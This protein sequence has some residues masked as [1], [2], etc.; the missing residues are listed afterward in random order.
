MSATVGSN[1][2]APEAEDA[3]ANLRLQALEDWKDALR[4]REELRR[5]LA[6]ALR[7][8]QCES[9]VPESPPAAPAAHGRRFGWAPQECAVPSAAPAPPLPIPSRLDAEELAEARQLAQV[10]SA[11][12]EFGSYGRVRRVFANLAARAVLFFA[13]VI[14]VQQRAFNTLV[15]R[16]VETS[17]TKL[18]RLADGGRRLQSE[19]DRIDTAQQ[20]LGSYLQGEMLGLGAALER[21]IAAATTALQQEMAARDAALRH[22]MAPLRRQSRDG[23]ASAR[24]LEMRLADADCERAWLR[25]A[26]V[27]YKEELRDALQRL[28]ALEDE[29]QTLRRS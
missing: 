5:R 8:D 25:L 16:F 14:T 9:V 29:V 21:E 13:G 24:E 20:G 6:T 27:E 12:P 17:D 19:I 4:R 28:R 11:M 23:D 10:G 2:P 18:G 1:G 22:E 15:L 7:D 3:G 26:A